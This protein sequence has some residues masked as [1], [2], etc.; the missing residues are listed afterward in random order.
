MGRK[1]QCPPLVVDSGMSRKGQVHEV[2]TTHITYTLDGVPRKSTHAEFQARYWHVC[3]NPRKGETF[4]VPDGN[5]L[6]V[7]RRIL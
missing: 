1:R 4:T 6:T 5:N 7:T 2:T 3:P